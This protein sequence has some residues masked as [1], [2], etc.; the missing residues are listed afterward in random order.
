MMEK[1]IIDQPSC[2]F[3][4]MIFQVDCLGSSCGLLPFGRVNVPDQVYRL[5]LA[6]FLHAG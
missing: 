5:W 6:L 2:I 1:L 4:Y 3:L